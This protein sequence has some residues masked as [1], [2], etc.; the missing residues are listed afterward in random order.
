MTKQHHL[1]LHVL[2]S[3]PRFVSIVLPRLCLRAWMWSGR[4]IQ[5]MVG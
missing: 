3:S 1:G 4:R 5:P 2:M